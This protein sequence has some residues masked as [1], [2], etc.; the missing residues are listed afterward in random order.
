MKNVNKSKE[1]AIDILVDIVG[2]MLIAVGVYNFAANSGFPVAGISGVA[3][4]FYHLFGLPIGTMTI[5]LNIPIIILCYKV[6]GKKFLLRSLK[7]MLI[8]W[9]LMD[10][11]RQCFRYM[12]E[13]DYCLRSAPVYFRDLAMRSFI[14]ATHL[15]AERIL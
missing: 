13:T 8:Q 4:I 14:F 9:P 7:T 5:V 1:F 12:K 2:N 15:Q 3:L 6:L 11:L 10:S